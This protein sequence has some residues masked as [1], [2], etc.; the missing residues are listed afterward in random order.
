MTQE[1]ISTD[2]YLK[3]AAKKLKVDSEKLAMF[4]VPERVI[5]VAVPITKGGKK[6]IYFGY[7]IQ[8]SNIL[9]PYKGG[10]RFHPEV[11]L[12]EVRILSSLMTW[13]NSLVGLPFGGAKGG[14]AIDPST[15]NEKELE[16]LTRAFTRQIADVIGPQKDIPAPDV[17]TTAQI[18]GW[19]RNEYEKIVGHKA[20]GVVT[21]KAIEDGGSQGRSAA[22]GEGG[23]AVLK[24]IVEHMNLDPSKLTVAI[25][26]F[27]NVGSFLAVGLEREGFQIQAISDAEGAITH[28]KGLNAWETFEEIH[29]NRHKL[30]DT[31]RCKPGKCCLDDCRKLSNADLLESDVDILIPA[32]VD[33][34][35]TENNAHKIKAKI[36][37][38]MANNPITPEADTILKER[39]IVI[40]PDI[41]ANAGGVTVSYFEW[42]Q[43]NNNERWSE[44]KVLNELR[45]Y[46]A[47]ATEKVIRAAKKYNCDYRTASY[48]IALERILKAQKL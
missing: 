11:D 32:A 19:I 35:I 13:K 6:Q 14:I 33:R 25:Q 46:M 28:K 12:T 27:G 22:T 2:I 26:G 8:H 18:M 40:I 21:G 29:K 48:I 44:E 41:L 7:R 42:L 4:A 39:G 37:L 10:L 24:N 16:E 23:V 43:N 9:G 38:E 34:Q 3:A 30:A 20:P 45:E 5:E 15:L 36:V 47:K 31:C 17:N 1:T